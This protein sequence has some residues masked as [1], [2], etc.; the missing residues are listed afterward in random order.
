[1]GT[2][3][4]EHQELK[5]LLAAGNWE[6]AQE[7]WLELAASRAD[8]P[9]FLLLLVDDF[10]TA[11]RADLAA[12]LAGLVAPTVK[13]SGRHHEWLYALKLQAPTK[14]R[15]A[16]LRGEL[17]EAYGQIYETDPRLFCILE[18]AGLDDRDTPLGTAIARADV[19]LA[20]A[21]G[22]W[23][24]HKSWGFGRVKAFDVMLQRV[25]VD[26][27]GNPEHALQLGYA[28]ESLTPVSPEHLEVRKVI[29]LSALQQLAKNEP[30]AVL[31]LA[32]L[33]RGR[34][35]TPG[36]IEASLAGTVVPADQ[37]KRWWSLA[38]KLAARDPH[39][40]VP[41][42]KSEP[43]RLRTA[44]VSQQDELL[45][46]FREA[47]GLPQKSAVTRQLLKSVAT[48]ANPDLLLQEFYDGLA[49]A[50]A[51]APAGKPAPRL[52]AA[53]LLEELLTH[54][55]SQTESAT[56]LQ[57]Q[58]LS[59]AGNL[60]DLLDQLSAPAQ[61][62]L[63]RVLRQ[64]APERLL[65]LVNDLP[66][67]LLDEIAD[68]LPSDADRIL[69]RVRNHTASSE[70][71]G[72]LCR[73]VSTGGGARPAWLDRLPPHVVLRSL[74]ASI[75]DAPTRSASKRLRD[76]LLNDDVLLTDLLAQAATDTVRDIARQILASHTFEELDR[77]SLMA[78]L[79]KEFP[80]V[81]ELLVSTTTK[82]QPLIV[83]WSSYNR[84]QIELEEIIQ[85]KIPQNS[86]EIAQ[87]RSYGDLREN[88]EFKA[89]R[90][91]QK[92]LMRQRAELELLLVRSQATDFSDVRSDSVQIGTSVTVTDVA[93]GQAQTYH[94]LGA[95]DSNPHQGIISYPAA[96]AQALLNHS[97]GEVIECAG[98]TAP[99]QLRID[100]VEKVPA[101]VLA[102]L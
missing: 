36:E 39:F 19:L 75:E 51:A 98:D 49:A 37:W 95:W 72:W 63:L 33:S 16:A 102:R 97:V 47:P 2:S 24:R 48:I 28:T 85:K 7:L 43:L 62:G 96:L 87:A 14:P 3:L 5:D 15:D 25:V 79:V 17:R 21:T 4:N 32:L 22:A 73:A 53:L 50:I 1:M 38:R 65:A 8:Q 20:L 99:Q 61:K 89:A 60:P 67:R 9:E 88:F 23:C 26:F 34:S 18:V 58:L 35:A 70:L 10:A 56:A 80:F 12:D 92:L 77:R 84:R 31:R 44:P 100:H 86:R 83:S 57:L 55:R 54:Q 6:Q 68:L 13:A 11:G 101:E 78:R 42:R 71:L 91:T 66:A 52:E 30:L 59:E 46:A 94:I 45:A 90:D 82:E 93:T 27:P 81:Q 74:L 76:L 64:A 41:E 29:D 69:Q 40:A